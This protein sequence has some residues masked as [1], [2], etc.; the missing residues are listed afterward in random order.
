MKAIVKSALVILFLMLLSVN[1]LYCQI[2]VDANGYVGIHSPATIKGFMHI[3][4]GTGAFSTAPRIDISSNGTTI[5][6]W[7]T[8]L[9][10][11]NNDL[12][13]GN[14]NRLQFATTKSNG[15]E[16]DFATLAVE[17]MNRTNGSQSGDLHLATVNCGAYASRFSIQ[18]TSIANQVKYFFNTGSSA[19]GEG[20]YIYTTNSAPSIYPSINNKGY[21][22]TSSNVWRY[23]YGNQIYYTTS[24]SKSSDIRLKTNISNI[25]ETSLEQILKLKGVKYQLKSELN[26]QSK[27]GTT[28][29][30]Y[31]GFIAQDVREV[32]PEV[33]TTD[34]QSGMYAIDYTSIIPVIV[35]AIKSQQKEIETLKAALAIMQEKIDKLSGKK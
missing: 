27:A 26:D 22:G 10:L 18:S 20:I 12:T 32:I 24:C 14:W 28:P 4:G 33:V 3:N 9:S 13:A 16:E 25:G 21:L 1:T 17:Y 15:E 30:F 34:T 19:A 29:N 2:K 35:E 5:I 23:I 11:Y 31:L 7:S 6:S 8:S